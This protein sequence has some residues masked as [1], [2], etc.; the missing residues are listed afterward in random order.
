MLHLL[1]TLCYDALSSLIT[2]TSLESSSSVVSERCHVVGVV[3]QALVRHQWTD[4]SL[5]DYEV[6]DDLSTMFLKSLRDDDDFDIF[7]DDLK[8]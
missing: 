3:S 5:D 8:S 1:L 6:V 7:E 2:T 4:D